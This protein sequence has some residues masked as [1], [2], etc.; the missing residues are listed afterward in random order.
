M[1]VRI[2]LFLFAIATTGACQAQEPTAWR[3]GTD[4]IYPASNLMDQWPEDGPEIIWTYEELGQGHSS[5]VVANGFVYAT[6][7]EE[8]TGYLFKFDM[9]GNLVYRK[10]YGPEY[11]ESFYGP[12]GT[13]VIVGDRVYLI[14]GYG[15]V[16]CLD[17][18]DAGKIWETNMVDD[19]GGEVIT[20]GYN[21]TPVIDGDK[22]YCTPGGKKNN[23]V[24]LNRFNGNVIWSC[25]GK[26]ELSAYCTPL[27]FNHNGRKILATH[28]ASHLLGIDATTGKLL[29]S[30]K[31]PNRYSVHANTPLYRDGGLFFFS[32]YGKGSGKLL[33]SADGTSIGLEWNNP[34]DSRMGGAV[35]LDGYIYGSGDN[36]RDWRCIDWATGKDMYT[37]SELG[38]GVVIA[39]DGK[40]YC[41]SDRGELALVNVTPDKY[42]LVSE[43]RVVEGSEQH[44]SHPVIHN[45]ILYLR[46]GK[47]LIAY[48]I[49]K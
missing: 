9:E 13:P 7:M 36:N 21:E 6:G 35:Y 42:D 18:S 40:L 2:L 5:P 47:A 25:P 30:H 1:N 23:V 28:T 38:K 33:L 48:Q 3:N 49:K 24:A 10:A 11:K 46:H 17:E 26:Q 44:W 29:W 45:G 16:Y 34:M 14:S 37:S 20:W 4:G 31:H 41:Y 32:G 19:L 12:R 22:I 15:N 8:G 39:A 27:L 43:T